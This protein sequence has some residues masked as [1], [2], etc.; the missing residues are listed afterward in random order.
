M[1]SLGAAGGAG[2]FLAHVF[3]AALRGGYPM[4][5]GI[6][7]IVANVLLVAALEVGN[8]VAAFVHV[9]ADNFF[10]HAGRRGFRRLH[11]SILRLFECGPSVFGSWGA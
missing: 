5:F 6:W 11:D 10:G 7:R 4:M 2:E 8:P 1:G 3:E 9:E